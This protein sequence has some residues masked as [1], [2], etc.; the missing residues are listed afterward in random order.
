MWQNLIL[1][2]GQM[3]IDMADGARNF[4]PIYEITTASIDRHLLRIGR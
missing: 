1:R 3:G 2:D 4:I